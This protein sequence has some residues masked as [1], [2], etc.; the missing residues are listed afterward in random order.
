MGAVIVRD[1]RPADAEIIVDFNIRLASES[2]GIT[3]DPVVVGPG[4][5]RA[6]A[7]PRLCRYFMAEIE[8]RPVG[9]T[10]ITTELTDW[11][12]GVLWWIQ[13]VYVHPDARRKGVFR[14][15][16]RHIEDTARGT[17]DVRGLR[18]YVDREND[19]AIRTYE[20]MGMNRT[21]YLFYERDW[22]GS[23]RKDG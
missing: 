16:H 10:M 2:E 17:A 4:V 23:I 8:G 12:N 18:L 7:S 20:A 21:N 1:A 5:R 19:K 3:L 11:R 9:Q 22:S 13:S 15:L 6:L 14:A